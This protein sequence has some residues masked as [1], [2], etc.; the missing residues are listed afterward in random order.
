VHNLQLVEG[1]QYLVE[2]HVEVQV[3]HTQNV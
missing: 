2:V 3:I 1:I